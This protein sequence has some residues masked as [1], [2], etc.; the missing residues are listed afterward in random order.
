[1]GLLGPNAGTCAVKV[2]DEWNDTRALCGRV[3]CLF[4]SS[5]FAQ[6]ETVLE[7]VRFLAPSA[8]DS[9]VTLLFARLFPASSIDSLLKQRVSS[10]SAGQQRLVALARVLLRRSPLVVLD[11]PEANLDVDSVARVLEVLCEVSRE[12]RLLILTH[13]SRF[14]E[15][16]QR[17]LR[18]GNDRAL[19]DP[20]LAEKGTLTQP[21]I[22]GPHASNP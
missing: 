8:S 2:G 4:Q 22:T 21:E 1:M 16:A 17:V 5:F 18:F 3:A 7:A 6:H 13:D 14:T 15:V 9:E 10:L 11:E 12:Q 20:M 19:R